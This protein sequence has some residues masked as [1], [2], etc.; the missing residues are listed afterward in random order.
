VVVVGYRPGAMV[1]I[2]VLT[3]VGNQISVLG[4]RAACRTDA[5]EALDAL[6]SGLIQP[7]IS[8]TASLDD[9]PAVLAELAAG[10]LLGRAVVVP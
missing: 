8:R 6:A 4:V 10:S 9:A 5:E 2:P 7:V 1:E 3:L